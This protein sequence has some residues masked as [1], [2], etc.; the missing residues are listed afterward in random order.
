MKESIA[1]IL[2]LVIE[3][4]KLRRDFREL[5]EELIKAGAS[6]EAADAIIA[7]LREDVAALR[8]PETL[9]TTKGDNNG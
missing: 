1:L 7:A 3:G 8:D 4:L 5:R 2:A 9:A 6:Q